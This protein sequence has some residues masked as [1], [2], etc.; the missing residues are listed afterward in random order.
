M[1]FKVVAVDAGRH[2][3]TVERDILAK[4]Q[5]ELITAECKSE[6][7]LIKATCDADGIL[8]SLSQI[9]R[10]VIS[11][12]KK[13][14]I[15]A[16]YGI[17]VDTVDLQAATD[18]G[19][20]VT[21]VPDFCYDEVSDTA[22]S[23]ILSVTRKVV[24]M[25]GLVSQGIWDR[26]LAIPVYKLR[27]RNLGLIAFGHIAQAVA[28]KA[29]PFGLRVSTYDPYIQ[30]SDFVDSPVEFLG[31]EELLKK[32]DIIS[33]HTPLTKQT[34]HLISEPQLR[35]MKP[36]AFLVNTAR[37]PVVD[38]VAL[39]KALQEGW[40]AGAGLDVLEQEPPDPQDPI[41]KLKNVVLTPHYASYTE[42]AYLEVREKAADQ[43][44][45]VLSGKIPNF[46]VNKNVL[47]K[48]D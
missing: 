44:V 46:L 42:E 36:T 7:D 29:A 8:V 4:V 30:P 11:S 40:I 1:K 20:F 5:V 2:A 3:P 32:S 37:G 21:N 35:M 18:H 43:I 27:G 23:L 26:K 25:H 41:L 10:R 14:K 15:I 13:N 28:K 22:M 47:E 9:T 33:I 45:Q 24:E 34:F 48:E 17:G 39:T 12:W 31:L 19:V 16:R 38:K 6:E